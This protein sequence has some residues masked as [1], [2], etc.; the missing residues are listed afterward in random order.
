LILSGTSGSA[1]NDSAP[2]SRPAVV[3]I[4]NW[5]P[6]KAALVRRAAAEAAFTMRAFLRARDVGKS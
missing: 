4:K 5:I 2:S 1:T 6:A 3:E